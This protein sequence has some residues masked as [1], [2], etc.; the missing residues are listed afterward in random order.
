MSTNE[1][2]DK[3]PYL[4]IDVM[5]LILDFADIITQP[6]PS[7]TTRS[8]TFGYLASLGSLRSQV[9]FAHD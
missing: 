5:Q 6:S 9:C 1:M 3:Q 4:C 2:T 7:S 8:I